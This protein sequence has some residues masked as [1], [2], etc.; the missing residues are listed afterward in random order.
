MR[1]LISVKYKDGFTDETI[2]IHFKEMQKW[3]YS[4]E[5]KELEKSHKES[6]AKAKAMEEGSGVAVNT[7]SKILTI[8]I[9]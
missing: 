1:E 8:T 7:I 3:T 2:N 6:I 4:Q 5:L 9:K